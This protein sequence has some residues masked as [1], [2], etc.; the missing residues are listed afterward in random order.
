MKKTILAVLIV[1]LF[2]PKVWAADDFKNELFTKIGALEVT[3]QVK[4]TEQYRKGWAYGFI[5]IDFKDLKD[6]VEYVAQDYEQVDPWTLM[7]SGDV[8]TSYIMHEQ[9]VVIYIKT[10]FIII[11]K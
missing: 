4:G 2:A 3:E 5:T 1:L 10:P 11:A 7:D 8:Y 9:A 6:I